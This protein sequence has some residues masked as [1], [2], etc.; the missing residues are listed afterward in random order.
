MRASAEVCVGISTIGRNDRRSFDAR[1]KPE[2]SSEIINLEE[3][4]MLTSNCI[5]PAKIKK[6]LVRY[7][8]A[9]KLTFRISEYAGGFKISAPARHYKIVAL[10][11]DILEA[12]SAATG[13]EV[14]RYLARLDEIKA[15][16]SEALRAI[17]IDAMIAETDQHD[18][19]M[20]SLREATGNL[21]GCVRQFA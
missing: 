11:A 7:C 1:R 6:P 9:N 3:T 18:A 5:Y 2:Q 12:A 17:S 16:S 13:I 15:G 20:G 19:R 8:E 4:D 14:E 21:L 10:A